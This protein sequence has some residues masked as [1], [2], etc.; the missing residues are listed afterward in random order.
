MT[1]RTAA[2]VVAAMMADHASI[3]IAH[4]GVA[5]EHATGL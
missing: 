5:K 1:R 3:T 4:G 2:T